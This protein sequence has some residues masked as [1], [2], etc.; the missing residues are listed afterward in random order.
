ME[1]LDKKE[2]IEKLKKRIKE[3]KKIDEHAAK[4]LEE[5]LRKIML[6]EEKVAV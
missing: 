4:N 6:S 3:V 5:L 2:I 1:I